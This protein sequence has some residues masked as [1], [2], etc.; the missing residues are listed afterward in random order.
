MPAIAEIGRVGQRPIGGLAQSRIRI[1]GV[2]ETLPRGGAEAD[3]LDELRAYFDISTDSTH[4]APRV[5]T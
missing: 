3:L 1:S 4:T 2:H 5:T